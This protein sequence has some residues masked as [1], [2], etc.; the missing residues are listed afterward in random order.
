MVAHL[1]RLKLVLLRNGLRR[2]V[3]QVIGLVVGTLYGL[4]VLVFMVAGM[5]ALS[6]QDGDVRA[7]VTIM[8]GSLLVAGWWVLPLLAFG[9]D[10]TL[11]PQRFV[12]FAIRRRTLL[13]G[14]ALAALVGIPGVMTVVAS[15]SMGAVWWKDPEALLVSLPGAALA[16]ALAVVGGRAVV[17][18]VA[19][20]VTRR[21]AREALAALAVLPFLLLW[22]VLASLEEVTFDGDTFDGV[23]RVL[24]WT[25]WGAAWS[26]PAD[27][28]RGAWGSAGLRLLIVTATL[29]VA[30]L[31]WD[32]SLARAL[33]QPPH[34]QASTRDRG[35][36]WFGRLPATPLGAVVARCLTYWARD[37]RYAISLILVP[38][39]PVVLWIADPGGDALL[40]S[41][42]I[43][44]FLLGWGLSNDISYD[45]SA[46]WMHVGAPLRGWVDRA[47]RIIASA[48]FAVPT[49]LVF[50]IGSAALVGR[51]DAVP[52]VLGAAFGVQLTAYGA[53]SV[54]SALVVYPVQA[55][56]E[57]PFQTKQG[58]S[59]A[60]FTSQMLGWTAVVLM[61]AP[62]VLL[63]VFAVLRSSELLGWSAL[64]VGPLL[65]SVLLVVGIRVG[66]ALLDRGA[67]DLLRRVTAFA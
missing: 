19:P 7:T 54:V 46:F 65:G 62:A 63:G 25:P 49:L 4:G 22:P 9:V 10:A 53:G 33:V 26:A 64:V 47:G 28:A 30:W 11:D 1:V 61:A 58:T 3:W 13:V 15:A 52:A 24:G 55:A 56:G 20:L 51:P 23:A 27:A 37:P 16:V 5:A 60:A 29:A 39:A 48:S 59:L 57:N 21:R 35:L 44:A 32:R 45:G 18:A 42:P 38:L 31:V 40:L 2:S 8:I 50:G 36:G 43:T 67:P 6:L 14:L 34:E 66:G 17:T 12:L 41:A